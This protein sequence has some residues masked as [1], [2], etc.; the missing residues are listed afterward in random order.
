MAAKKNAANQA[1]VVFNV[2]FGVYK[3]KVAEGWKTLDTIPANAAV[4][5]NERKMRVK[6][7]MRE[8]IE[9]MA[10]EGVKSTKTTDLVMPV[11]AVMLADARTRGGFAS[12][13][14][15]V[16]VGSKQVE[17]MIT[18]KSA[19]TKWLKGNVLYKSNTQGE[20]N[21]ALV[22]DEGLRLRNTA[23]RVTEKQPIYSEK[24]DVLRVL[25]HKTAE[26]ICKQANLFSGIMTEA[27]SLFN[28]AYAPVKEAKEKAV[29]KAA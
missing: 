15:V 6:D 27:K 28:A 19:F 11:L 14:K 22:L 20:L 29:E 2:T 17:T 1:S 21:K 3:Y 4:L 26:A 12:D 9:F 16:T 10:V 5:L 13:F 24:G 7:E 23:L 18:A 8:V 25:M